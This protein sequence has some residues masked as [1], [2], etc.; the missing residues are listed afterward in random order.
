MQSFLTISFLG[1]EASV[2]ETIQATN[3][4]EMLS[5]AHFLNA[6]VERM[7]KDE[8]TSLDIL[9]AYIHSMAPELRDWPYEAEDDWLLLDNLTLLADKIQ[10]VIK[11][12]I[13]IGSVPKYHS[14]TDD[15]ITM[16]IATPPAPFY[17]L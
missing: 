14:H 7:H 11:P 8:H 12:M 2:Q 4:G 3:Y 1:L 17:G 15:S 9:F 6:V 10:R 13:P 5:T 16:I